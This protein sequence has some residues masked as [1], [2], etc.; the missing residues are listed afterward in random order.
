MRVCGAQL[1]VETRST[2]CASGDGIP[3]AAILCTMVRGWSKIAPRVS[4]LP[5]V[6]LRGGLLSRAWTSE[7]DLVSARTTEGEH[8]EEEDHRRPGAGV[9][10]SPAPAPAVGGPGTD[11]PRARVE[12][13]ETRQDRQPSA[14]ALESAL[15]A[16][17]R[18]S[19]RPTFRPADTPD[20]GTESRFTSFRSRRGLRKRRRFAARQA[21]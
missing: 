5:W 2:P 1:S 13:E 16:V 21:P 8:A 10:R 14:G 18:G 20:R 11:G 9:G 3:E 19:V 15:A 4:V 12:P 17:H 7:A 6:R